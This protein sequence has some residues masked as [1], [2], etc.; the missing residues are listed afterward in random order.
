MLADCVSAPFSGIWSHVQV[1][2]SHTL[3]HPTTPPLFVFLPLSHPL[4]SIHFCPSPLLPSPHPCIS[5]LPTLL[6]SVDGMRRTLTVFSHATRRCWPLLTRKWFRTWTRTSS[7]DSPLSTHST[8]GMR[9]PVLPQSRLDS[10]SSTD[11]QMPPPPHPPCIFYTPLMRADVSWVN[12]AL[13]WHEYT[14][15]VHTVA[16]SLERK[17]SRSFLAQLQIQI[18]FLS[19]WH[20]CPPVFCVW[21]AQNSGKRTVG[22][23][24]ED[25]GSQSGAGWHTGTSCSSDALNLVDFQNKSCA[26][27]EIF[28]K[29]AHHFSL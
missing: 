27:T 8:P 10:S 20:V 24:Q 1:M 6:N 18:P 7:R 23:S 14:T 15:F 22:V 17:T 9:P 13:N 29:E 2:S 16:T 25:A 28:K 21:E 3:V 19:P 4:H 5:S 26:L 11:T 12:P